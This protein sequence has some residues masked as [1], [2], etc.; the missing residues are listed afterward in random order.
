MSRPRPSKTDHQASV[1]DAPRH[2]QDKIDGLAATPKTGKSLE[3]GATEGVPTP[4]STPQG[5][6]E[7]R[8]RLAA[9]NATEVQKR[10]PLPTGL[11]DRPLDPACFE[12]VSVSQLELEAKIRNQFRSIRKPG[13]EKVAQNLNAQHRLGL[14]A[15]YV[16]SHRE[17]WGDYR[18]VKLPADKLGALRH[19]RSVRALLATNLKRAA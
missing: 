16:E 14:T 4:S 10:A 19:S 5:R 8:A 17:D 15:S 11:L 1:A 3:E 12:E 9:A 18:I 2:R 7:L 13:A 6:R